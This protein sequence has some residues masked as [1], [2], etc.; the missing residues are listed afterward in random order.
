[1]CTSFKH[2]LIFSSKD[3]LIISVLKINIIIKA[4]VIDLFIIY[5]FTYLFVHWL[6]G[7]LRQGFSVHPI[8]AVLDSADQAGLELPLP[9]ENGD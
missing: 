6:V 2:F 4:I 1:M 5:S 8:L 7:F 9:P 3:V